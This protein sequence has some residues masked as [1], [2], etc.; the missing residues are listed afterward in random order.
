MASQRFDIVYAP[1]TIAW[2]PQ[3][4]YVIK[5]SVEHDSRKNALLKFLRDEFALEV[6]PLDMDATPI[7]YALGCGCD[8]SV[9]FSTQKVGLLKSLRSGEKVVPIARVGKDCCSEHANSKP[10]FDGD[11]W[12]GTFA[13]WTRDPKRPQKFEYKT[14]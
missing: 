2:F 6:N 1:D 14:G 8:V 3:N 5:R 9:D 7:E 4:M 11:E 10:P 13:A 12:A